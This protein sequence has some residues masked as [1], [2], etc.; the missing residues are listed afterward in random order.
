MTTPLCTVGS[1][2]KSCELCAMLCQGLPCE[3]LL[4]YSMMSSTK[5]A[6]EHATIHY[7]PQML[8]PVPVMI[9]AISDSCKTNQQQA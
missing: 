8:V 9:G 7:R 1:N 4:L 6:L 2:G 3:G 5:P